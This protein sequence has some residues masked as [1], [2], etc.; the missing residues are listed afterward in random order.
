LFSC[1]AGFEAWLARELTKLHGA[2]VAENASGWVRLEGGDGISGPA[3]SAALATSRPEVAA[4]PAPAFAHLTLLDPVE[5][6]GASRRGRPAD[7][8]C[9]RAT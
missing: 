1:Q 3:V 2:T 5:V 7:R 6:R 4:L 8:Y 9:K